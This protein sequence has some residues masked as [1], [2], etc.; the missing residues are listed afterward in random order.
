MSDDESAEGVTQH[1]LEG[2]TGGNLVEY[3]LLVALIFLV[4]LTAVQL[5][6]Q[7]ATDKMSCASSAI[8]S[9]AGGQTC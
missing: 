2:D 9:S 7:N 6:G 4:A 5:F 8:T 1:R 3:A